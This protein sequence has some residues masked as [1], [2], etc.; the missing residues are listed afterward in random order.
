MG[1]LQVSVSEECSVYLLKSG[2]S[3]GISK[4]LPK[5]NTVL[6][7]EKFPKKM[8]LKPPRIKV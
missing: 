8:K 4:E 7:T 3:Q 2:Q 6:A 5:V 1:S